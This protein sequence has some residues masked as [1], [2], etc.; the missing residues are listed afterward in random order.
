MLLARGR[1]ADFAACCGSVR[2]APD[3]SATL[4]RATAAMLGIEPGE[5]FLAMGR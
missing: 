2:I 5:T 4:D 1:L 3:E